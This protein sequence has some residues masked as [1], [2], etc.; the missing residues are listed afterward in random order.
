M[1]QNWELKTYINGE[2]NK[3]PNFILTVG[4]STEFD[5]KLFQKFLTDSFELFLSIQSADPDSSIYTD[6]EEFSAQ[7]SKIISKVNL[8]DLLDEN[9]DKKDKNKRKI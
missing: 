1:E 7:I 2:Q 9:T 3:N 4:H 6:K 5:K 8:E